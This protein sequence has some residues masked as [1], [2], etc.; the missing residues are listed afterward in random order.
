MILLSKEQDVFS[1]DRRKPQEQLAGRAIGHAARSAGRGGNRAMMEFSGTA[2]QFSVF[3]VSKPGVLTQVCQALAKEKVNI[4]ALTMMD[5][6]EHGV[7]RLIAQDT[8]RA[9]Y[10]LRR[11]NLPTAETDVVLAELPNRPGAMAD[12]CSRLGA[13]HITINYAYCT[14]NAMN[15]RS[16]AVLKV[17]DL[18][19]AIKLLEVRKPRRKEPVIRPRGRR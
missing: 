10:A 8:D 4:I 9:R 18:K 19:R 12:L 13:D 16:L 3:L 2:T 17:S 1:A 11:L 7:L 5:S 14:G 6:N 15:G